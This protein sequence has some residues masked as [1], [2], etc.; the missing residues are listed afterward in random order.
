M[1][2]SLGNV[3][4]PID[5]IEGIT[6]EELHT[7]LKGKPYSALLPLNGPRVRTSIARTPLSQT[8]SNMRAESKPKNALLAVYDAI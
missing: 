5:V 8:C 4:D 7:K 2:K 6:L 3:I 1:S